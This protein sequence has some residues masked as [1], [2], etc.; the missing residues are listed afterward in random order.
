MFKFLLTI[1][2]DQ[3]SVMVTGYYSCAKRAQRGSD[4]LER[5]LHIHI[6]HLDEY[7]AGIL[8]LQMGR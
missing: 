8:N 2:A 7:F 3:I 6:H 5:R 1:D 4:A